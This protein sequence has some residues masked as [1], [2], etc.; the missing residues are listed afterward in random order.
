MSYVFVALRPLLKV[1]KATSRNDKREV[2]V[3]TP[4]AGRSRGNKATKRSD[5]QYG[6]PEISSPHRS[7]RTLRTT[8]FQTIETQETLFSGVKG[9]VTQI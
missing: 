3:Q 5:S 7:Q 4:F 1:T 6:R 2:S 9:D 8:I